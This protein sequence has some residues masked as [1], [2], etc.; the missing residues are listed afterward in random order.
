MKNNKGFTLTELLVTIVIMGIITAIAFPTITKLQE[1]NKNERYKAYTKVLLHG[2][3]LYVDKYGSDMDGNCF[4]ITKDKLISEG[5]VKEYKNN[6]E[7]FNGSIQIVKNDNN[8]TYKK[9]VKVTK[10]SKDIY[11]DK[12]DGYSEISCKKI[13]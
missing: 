3:K 4:I 2:T 1:E 7:V 9:S 5:L 8:Y 10:N 6:N 12:D 13:E 11:I